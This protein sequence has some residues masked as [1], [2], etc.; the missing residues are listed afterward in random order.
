M[1][2][3]A[4]RRSLVAILGLA[5]ALCLGA[6]MVEGNA[7]R[8]GTNDVVGSWYAVSRVGF[9]P[10]EVTPILVSF[11]PDGLLLATDAYH[12]PAHGAWIEQGPD[13]VAY[14]YT[15]AHTDDRGVFTGT[16]LWAGTAVLGPDGSSWTGELTGIDRDPRGVVFGQTIFPTLPDAG[17]MIQAERIT[18]SEEALAAIGSVSGDDLSLEAAPAGATPAENE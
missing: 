11:F 8:D 14:T 7:T 4:P 17:P 13:T 6:P 10:E 18:V 3:Q 9:Q 1:S 5:V 16:T 12:Q 2:I 15:V